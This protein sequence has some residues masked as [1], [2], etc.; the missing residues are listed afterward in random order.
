[1]HWL[2]SLSLRTRLLLL[3]VLVVA[4]GFTLTISL[5]TMRSAQL[6]EKTAFAYADELAA[7]HG[8]ESVVILRKALETARTLAATLYTMKDGRH[9]DRELGAAMLR[10]TLEQSPDFIGVWLG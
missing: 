10:K 7:R 6:Q 2:T 1:M 9:A 8:R 5:V 3:V 4:A